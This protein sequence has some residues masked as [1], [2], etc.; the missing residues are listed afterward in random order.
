M[1]DY[2]GAGNAEY[3]SF[4]FLDRLIKLLIR[5]DVLSTAEVVTL[6]G[7]LADDMSQNPSAVSKRNVSY[8][9]DTM[10]AEHKP[11]E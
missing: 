1:A 2:P 5:K 4:C 6:L 8:V 11:R 7:E 10:I 3:I 9:R